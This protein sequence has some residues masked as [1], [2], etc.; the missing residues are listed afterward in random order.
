M[1]DNNKD[2]DAVARRLDAVAN[3]IAAA[4]AKIKQAIDS[5]LLHAGPNGQLLD[6]GDVGASIVIQGPRYD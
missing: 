3:R 2:D 5:G 6:D 1:A 4:E